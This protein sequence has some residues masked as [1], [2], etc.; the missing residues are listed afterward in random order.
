MS[1]WQSSRNTQTIAAVVALAAL[2]SVV[3]ISVLVTM[4]VESLTTDTERRAEP[5]RNDLRRVNYHLSRQIA[6]LTRYATTGD[7]EHLNEY[8]A[9][10]TA[11]EGAM[12]AL[13]ADTRALGPPF[14]ERF[15]ELQQEVDQWRRT[16]DAALTEGDG[17]TASTADAAAYQG[18]YPA[19]ISAVH[20]LDR[21]MTRF[22]SARR[23]ETRRLIRLAVSLSALL[24]LVAGIAG[25]TVLR[26]A[27]QLR[28][29]ATALVREAEERTAALD[30]EREI[31]RTA[32]SL[33]RSRD[34]ILGVV[35]HD[36]RSPLTAIALSS[37]MIEA[38]GAPEQ[39][40]EYIQT[41]LTSARRM[42]RL[43]EDLLD[44]T[45]IENSSLSIR[46]ERVDLEAVINEVMATHRPIAA[47]KKIRLTA[48]VDGPLPPIMGDPDRL[49][50]ALTNLVGNALKFTPE[51]G[52]VRL[53]T[54]VR[55]GIVRFTVSDTGPGIAE[56]DLPHIF[57]PFFQSKKTA[58]LGAGLGLKIVRAIVESHG[59]SITVSN[60]TPRGAC[61]T[62]DLPAAAS[63]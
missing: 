3:A 33:V 31:R 35:S 13:A 6:A 29:A 23:D 28:A 14:I 56:S 48:T 62:V 22:Q 5:V 39:R 61:F 30:R 27:A 25:L 26:M 32:E 10:R 49:V 11:H 17:D 51:E 24:V 54:T 15:T 19:I 55:D 21:E 44:V 2:V 42:E 43:I 38:A 4:R 20:R 63:T 53:D 37:Q 7:E 60:D 46:R 12:E 57:E 16:V 8:Q 34:E 59:G 18:R 36:L 47:E 45:K 58:H 52:R 1:R 40:A 9:A 50:Q 41:I